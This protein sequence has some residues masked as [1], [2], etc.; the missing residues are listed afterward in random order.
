MGAGMSHTPGPWELAPA[1][2][3]PYCYVNSATWGMLASVVVRMDGMDCSEGA[4]NARLIAAAP[5][6]LEALAM[7]K[8]KYGHTMNRIDCSMVERAIRAARGAA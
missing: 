5:E 3:S 4:A 7:V 6:L 8:L 2:N 1:Q